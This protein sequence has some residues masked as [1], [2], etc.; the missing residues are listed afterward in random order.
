MIVFCQRNRVCPEPHLALGTIKQADTSFVTIL[1]EDTIGGLQVLHK[2]TWVDV[3]PVKGASIVNI[4]DMMQIE[5]RHQS[6]VNEQDK[7]ANAKLLYQE[8]NKDDA[9]DYDKSSDDQGREGSLM[10][11]AFDFI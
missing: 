9:V 8:L 6:G 2:Y 5:S 3:K 7:I 11:D 10:D 4:G 1:V